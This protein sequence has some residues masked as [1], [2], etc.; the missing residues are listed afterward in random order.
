VVEESGNK[1]MMTLG[2]RL[3]R[4]ARR[5]GARKGSDGRQGMISLRWRLAVEAVLYVLGRWF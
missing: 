3:M 4:A 2:K 1:K 5:K